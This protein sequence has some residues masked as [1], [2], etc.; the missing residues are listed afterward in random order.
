MT[1]WD[2]ALPWAQQVHSVMPEMFVSFVL[3]QWADETGYG[4]Y[5]WSVAHNPG[6]V[7]SFDGQP[8][9][10]FPSLQVGVQAYMQCLRNGYY[11]AVLAAKTWQAQC[12][13]L[14]RSPWASAHY[15][16]SGPPPGQDLVKIV[17][18]NNLTRFDGP[19]PP[20]PPIPPLPPTPK[21]NEMIAHDAKSGGN[22]IVRPNGNVYTYDG[23]PYL[24]PLVKY[25]QQWGI[26]TAQ[27]PVVGIDSDGEGGFILGVENVS[28]AEPKG[29]YHITSDAQYAK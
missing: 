3:A 2:E 6:N 26:G 18:N 17:Q 4:G 21:E 19:P 9:N 22:W 10:H 1:F 12:Y 5:D 11:N 14:G 28:G 25:L 8:V 15:M 13:A 29:T 23:A 24:G 20:P 27:C 7:G 16:A